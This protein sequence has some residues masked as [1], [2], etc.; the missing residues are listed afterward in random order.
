MTAPATATF[1]VVATGT[2]PLGYQWSKN[3]AAIG[4]ATGSSYTTPPT[5]SGDNGSTFAVTVSNAAGSQTS[6][7]ATLTVSAAPVADGVMV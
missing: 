6:S 4:G 1:S 7:S 2:A 5:V 3:G